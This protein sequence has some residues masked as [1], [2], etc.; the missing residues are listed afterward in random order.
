MAGGAPPGIAGILPLLVKRS[1]PAERLATVNAFVKC[2]IVE[3]VPAQTRCARNE[4]RRSGG[5]VDELHVE[6]GDTTPFRPC[7][8]QDSRRPAS[9]LGYGDRSILFARECAD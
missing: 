3:V 6:G 9:S 1:E 5:G 4:T 7:A 8:G 2:A